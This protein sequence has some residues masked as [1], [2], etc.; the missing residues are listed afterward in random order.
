MMIWS[1]RSVNDATRNASIESKDKQQHPNYEQ[2]KYE[3]KELVEGRYMWNES[4][5]Y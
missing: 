5:Y 1:M 3:T 2:R 4:D